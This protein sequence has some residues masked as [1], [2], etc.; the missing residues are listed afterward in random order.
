MSYQI[1]GMDVQSKP[2][3]LTF[4]LSKSVSCC[5]SRCKEQ[6]NGRREESNEEIHKEKKDDMTTVSTTIFLRQG[7]GWAIFLSLEFPATEKQGI[8]Y[9]KHWCFLPS[10]LLCSSLQNDTS[11]NCWLTIELLHFICFGL[12]KKIKNLVGWYSSS[13]AMQYPTITKY[14]WSIIN[15]GSWGSEHYM[16]EIPCLLS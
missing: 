8:S 2:L 6:E 1:W 4:V 11:L 5:G 14:C 13:C 7:R 10:F 16:R 9:K 12:E 15:Q 3:S